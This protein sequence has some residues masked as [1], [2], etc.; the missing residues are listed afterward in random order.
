MTRL[1]NEAYAEVATIAEPVAAVWP[2]LQVA[3][4]LLEIPIEHQDPS[5]HQ[6]GNLNFRPRRIG[7]DRLSKFLDCG[8]GNTARQNADTYAVTMSVMTTLT[9]GD[10]G[11]DTRVETLVQ[12]SAKARDTSSRRVTC[13][14]KGQLE[15]M[16]AEMIGRG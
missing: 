8:Q 10:T 9:P 5:R 4:G 6:L 1:S 11:A 14:S 13:A 16:I 7:G 3:Y 12:A 15:M 2:R